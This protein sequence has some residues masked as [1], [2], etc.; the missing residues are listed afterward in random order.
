MA[1][2]AVENKGT[3]AGNWTCL[4]VCGRMDAAMSAEAEKKI[5]EGL[6]GSG[7]L[8][9]DLSQ[10]DYISCA[11]LRV[12]LRL[13]KAVNLQKK[14]LCLVQ[15]SGFVKAVLEDSGMDVYFRCV[16]DAKKL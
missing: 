3:T 9:L 14:E 8:A 6:D 13:A 1:D 15:A 2:F 7:K 16:D 11:G 12:L 10:V 4:S 5:W